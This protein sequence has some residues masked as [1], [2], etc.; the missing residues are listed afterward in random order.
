MNNSAHRTAP[1]QTPIPR[2]FSLSNS[3]GKEKDYESGFHYYGARY[4][5]SEGLTGWLS[6]DPMADKYPSISPYAYCVW[7][8]VKL[9]D[10]EGND[11]IYGEI[12]GGVSKIGD[13]GKSEGNS[14]FVTGWTKYKVCWATFLGRNYT[15]SLVPS[16]N[17][18]HVPTGN[19]ATAVQTTIDLVEQSEEC[20]NCP[21]T[22]VEYGAHS[23][24]GVDK[25][26][27]WD[28]GEPMEQTT[29][30][31][32][33]KYNKWSITPFIKDGKPTGGNPSDV[34]FVWHVQP[35]NSMPSQ[36]DKR[37][38]FHFTYNCG[39]ESATWF[40]VGARD[41]KVSFLSGLGKVHTIDM[42]DF[43]KMSLLQ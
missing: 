13:D 43:Q 19:V 6:V 3:N 41:G 28:P 40:V 25:A 15:G 42:V 33:E 9:M 16:E 26:I 34:E 23:M 36:A 22:Q 31:G 38:A 29:F 4:Y 12:G 18:F 1:L 2:P 37:A 35:I 30:K 32:D 14:Y 10:P 5:W 39:M 21:W 8:P 27:I 11:P 20:D 17:V 24:Y 7:N